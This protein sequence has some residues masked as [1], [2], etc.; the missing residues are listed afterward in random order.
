MKTN[1]KELIR[2]L[3]RTDLNA[4]AD[5]VF[6]A[7]MS[8]NAYRPT[9]L[10][11]AITAALQK[12]IDG[13]VRRQIIL[14]PPRMGKSIIT[15]VAF[16]AFLF[17]QNPA[18]RFMAISHS[19]ALATK[20]HNAFRNI[21]RSSWS[22]PL[23]PNLRFATA[24]KGQETIRDTARIIETTQH[25]FRYSTSMSGSITGEGADWIAMDDPMNATH[26]NSEAE[27]NR[28]NAAYD[29]AIASRLN[30]KD[31]RMLL[32]MQR[33]H[34]DDLAG[35]LI[36]KGGW[37]VLRI[38]AIGEADTEYDLGNGRTYLRKKGTLI[39]EE[40]FGWPDI[41]ERRRDLG[42]IAFQAQYQQDPEPPG[43][44]IFKRA[45]LNL[46][47]ELPEF[48]RTVVSVDIATTEGGG[49]YSVVLV[50]G[51]RDGIWYLTHRYR[52]QVSFTALTKQILIVDIK[53]EPD[54]IMVE[55]NGIG[56]ALIDR[57]REVGRRNVDGAHVGVDKE[58]RARG[59]TPIMERGEVKIW[60][61]I[62]D[63]ESF[64][65]ELLSFPSGKY[66]D[67]VDAFTLPLYYRRD[68]L[69]VV[70]ASRREKRNPSRV[71]V[72]EPSV[73]TLPSFASNWNGDRWAAR[74]DRRL[75]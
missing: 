39:D 27:R 51:I 6:L 21:V 15:S 54:L 23:N 14:T 22:R 24:H 1:D 32:I 42:S 11:Q 40:R 12:M 70:A 67:Q 66:D 30:S 2:R 25:G 28:V 62:P 45:W 38:P 57:L 34:A 9:W 20:H 5:R 26:A 60:R 58:D 19:D 63:L 7:S 29:E 35:H 50:W 10:T 4:Y 75:W 71:L 68:V 52:K 56:N 61:K 53:H 55:R 65:N 43:G 44:Q 49:D 73:Y 17:V 64:I 69:R 3:L 31:G 8:P 46:V 13:P 37:N 41:E 36:S 16:P 48:E 72:V 59:I 74:N 47:D 33:L 18:T